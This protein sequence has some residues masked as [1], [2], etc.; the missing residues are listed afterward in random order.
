MTISKSRFFYTAGLTLLS[1]LWS[2]HAVAQSPNRPSNSSTTIEFNLTA[3]S[4]PTPNDIITVDLRSL[5]AE[6]NAKGLR[7]LPSRIVF[8]ESDPLNLSQWRAM[9]AAFAQVARAF[10]EK[11]L[12]LVADHGNLQDFPEICYRGRTDKVITILRILKGNRRDVND[13]TT[14]PPTVLSEEQRIIANRYAGVVNVPKDNPF[15]FNRDGSIQRTKTIRTGHPDI[16]QAWETFDPK[17]DDLLVISNSGIDA[18]EDDEI[19][20]RTIRRCR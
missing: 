11:K 8:G 2:G 13:T 3:I 15:L 10:P 14:R 5:A 1:I 6:M 9:T 7:P 20:A 19:Y 18:D 4:Y 12:R 16:V 17:S